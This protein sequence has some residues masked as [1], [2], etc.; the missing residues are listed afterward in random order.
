MQIKLTMRY[1][2]ISTSMAIN[3]KEVTS[4]GKNGEKLEPS[5]IDRECE[6]VQSVWKIVLRFL[7]KLTVTIRLAILFLNMY[8]R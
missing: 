4:T 7:K 2:F 3:K 1:H 6:M 8:Q 5:Y